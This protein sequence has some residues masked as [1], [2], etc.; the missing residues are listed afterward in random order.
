LQHIEHL[1]KKYITTLIS[2]LN[3]KQALVPSRATVLHNAFGT[4]PGLWMKKGEVSYFFLP[5]VPYEMKNLIT[6]AVLPGIMETYDRPDIVHENILTYGM[7][8]S[9]VADNCEDWEN[10]FPSH[11]ILA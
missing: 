11:I 4:A 10:N 1:F 2:D 9:A 6:S 7:G 8:V 5:G 3:R